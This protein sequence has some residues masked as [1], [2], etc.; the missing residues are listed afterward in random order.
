MQNQ[1]SEA[2]CVTKNK[3]IGSIAFWDDFR[4]MIIIIKIKSKAYGES[5]K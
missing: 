1:L 5:F 3:I 4:C 2:V